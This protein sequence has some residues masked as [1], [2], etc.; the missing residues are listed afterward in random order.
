MN[1]PKFTP[2][3]WKV[4]DGELVAEMPTCGAMCVL[5]Q[6]YGAD[7]YPCR[8]DD[9]DAECKANARLIAAAPDLYAALKDLWDRWGMVDWTSVHDAALMD[10]ARAAIARAEGGGA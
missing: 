6:I 10:A 1:E 9:I 5:G 7:D 2:G 4:E 3:P 8:D